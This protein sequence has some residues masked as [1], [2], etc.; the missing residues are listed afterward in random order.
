M[1]LNRTERKY[2]GKDIYFYHCAD[3][4]RDRGGDCLVFKLTADKTRDADRG[5][6]KTRG[7]D[8]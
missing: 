2:H 1:F 8:H 4:N 7:T 5:T 6:D 3:R